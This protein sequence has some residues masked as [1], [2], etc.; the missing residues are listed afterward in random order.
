MKGTYSF[1]TSRELK[2]RGWLRRQLEIQARGLCGNLDRIWPDIRDSAWIGGNR[3]GWERVPYWLDG[4]VPL[5]YLLEDEDLIAR[6]QRYIDS[7]LARQ[8][9]DGW[10]CPVAPENRKNY[11]T[12]AILLISKALLRYYECSGDERVPSALYR[13]MK[14]FATLL[15]AGEIS[16]V[17]WGKYRWF[18]GFPALNFLYA[19]QPEEWMRALARRLSAEGMDYR[20]AEHAWVRPL[21]KWTFETHIVNICMMLKSE[22]LSADLLGEE[23]TG[24]A[25]REY[26][27][28]RRYNG[29]AV[30]TL[31]GDECLAGTSPTQGTELCAVVELMDS[32]EQLYAYT[33]ATEWAERL[34]TVA[35]NALPATMTEDMWAHQYVQMVNQVD[36]TPF[37]GRSH[38]RTNRPTAHMFGLEPN[39]GCC[40]ANFGQGYPKLALSAFLRAKDGVHSAV[41]LPSEVS[42]VWEGVPVTV[43]LE[44]DYPFRNRLCYRVRTEKK[45]DM[46]L[47]V[48]I[49]SFARELTVNGKPHAARRVL[50]FSGFGEGVTEID[51][52]FTA[53]PHLCGRPHGM[54]VLRYGS[55]VFS[56]PVEAEVERLE[57]EKDGVE[58]KFPYCDYNYKGISDWNVGFSDRNFHVSEHPI[59]EIPFSESH[60]PLTIEANLAHV[61]WEWEDGFET[62]PARLPKNR[63]PL[64]APQVRR[65]IP[66]GCTM[67]RVTEIPLLSSAQQKE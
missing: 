65:M 15:E 9:P 32:M 17:N 19:R 53:E 37:P 21:N 48:R 18:E 7:I 26:D 28:L 52:F 24:F 50:R 27:I 42:L 45:T 4:V 46:V 10:I 20:E 57:Y 14:N 5:A 29:T 39:Y 33:G 36:C 30:G 49:P 8:E 13:M 62:V 12:W 66:Y 63:R 35:Y 16:L 22:V 60:P 56:L 38:F 44:T 2:P 47:S 23:M 61:D 1:F 41:P 67:L 55:L 25:E 34:E 11:D 40:T 58:R 59:G 6:T 54:S 3:E 64:D 51:I 43:S 31:T